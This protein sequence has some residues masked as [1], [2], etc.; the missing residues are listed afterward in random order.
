MLFINSKLVRNHFRSI[1]RLS[2]RLG[3]LYQNEQ[4]I[5]TKIT[6]SWI[7]CRRKKIT[8]YSMTDLYKMDTICQILQFNFLAFI[9]L[10]T[11]ISFSRNHYIKWQK[12]KTQD[13]KKNINYREDNK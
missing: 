11:I 3:R 9:K 4:A 10:Y 2:I 1:I 13:S 6:S 5:K 12:K 8:S 7:K